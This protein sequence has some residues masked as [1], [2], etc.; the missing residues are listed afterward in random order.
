MTSHDEYQVYFQAHQHGRDW[1][2]RVTWSQWH[3]DGTQ[4]G[5]KTYSRHVTMPDL[6]D[7]DWQAAVAIG[8]G[9]KMMSALLSTPPAPLDEPDEPLPLV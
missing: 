6:T 7:G 5:Q 9:Y 4:V 2:I 8:E 3:E 1:V